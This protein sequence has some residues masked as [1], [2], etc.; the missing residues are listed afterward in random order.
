MRHWLAALILI[1][2]FTAPASAQSSRTAVGI[3]EAFQVS[4]TPPPAVQ[5][6]K[7]IRLT[8]DGTPVGAER[9]ILDPTAEL[10]IDVPG[11]AAA[12]AHRL[13]AV[14]VNDAGPG[15]ATALNFWVG[16]PSAPG[17]RLQKVVTEQVFQEVPSD[18]GEITLKL[19]SASTTVSE[20]K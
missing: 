20:V 19:V 5:Q 9:T 7:S 13:E 8:L 10:I 4:I 16:P 17:L 11:I 1:L 2:G 18:S 3:G 15:P 12:G 6:P 14:A